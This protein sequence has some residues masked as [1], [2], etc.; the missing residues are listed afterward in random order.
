MLDTSTDFVLLK[1]CSGHPAS[2]KHGCVPLVGARD[3]EMLKAASDSRRKDFVSDVLLKV[4]VQ[5]CWFPWGSEVSKT[6]EGLFSVAAASE[7]D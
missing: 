2:W 5:L 1:S 7:R 4:V 3:V 6:K